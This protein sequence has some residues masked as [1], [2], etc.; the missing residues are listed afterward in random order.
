[1][2]RRTVLAIAIVCGASAAAALAF[3]SEISRAGKYLI[4]RAVG[5]GRDFTPVTA[6]V[7]VDG[8]VV[9]APNEPP[10]GEYCLFPP[11]RDSQAATAVP[12]DTLRSTSIGSAPLVLEGQSRI[13]DTLPPAFCTGYTVGTPRVRARGKP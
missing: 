11:S 9:A 12:T 4:E 8:R 7:N 10:R 6:G 3:A 1:M 13:P 5:E 2:V